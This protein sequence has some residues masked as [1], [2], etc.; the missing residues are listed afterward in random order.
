[1]LAATHPNVTWALLFLGFSALSIN[2]A[3]VPAMLM[4]TVIPTRRGI[5]AAS[6]V[7]F[8]KTLGDAASPYLVGSVSVPDPARTTSVF[9]QSTDL[10]IR[11]SASTHP[12]LQISD[13]ICGNCNRTMEPQAYFSSLR[14][15]ML[16]S[17]SVLI[18]GTAFFVF[19]MFTISADRE[20][21]QEQMQGKSV[22]LKPLV[23]MM[24]RF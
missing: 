22:L 18:I 16:L 10:P 12:P 2:G 5:A 24:R 14:D 20:R 11:M 1:M 7:F 19:N 6:Q 21:C 8:S 15:A 9:G 17:V 13:T 23:K 4:Y 3:L